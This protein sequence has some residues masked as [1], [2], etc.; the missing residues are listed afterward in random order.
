MYVIFY[1]IILCA[2]EMN[3]YSA[4]FEAALL[5]WQWH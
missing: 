5:A 1:F 3:N 2:I 4:D